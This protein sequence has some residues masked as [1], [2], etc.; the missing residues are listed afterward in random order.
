MIKKKTYLAFIIALFVS[1]SAFSQNK[2]SLNQYIESYKNVAMDEMRIY[3]IPASIKLAQGVLESGFG[4]SDLA[5]KANNHFGIKCSGW[6]GKTFIKDDDAKDECFRSYN[7]AKQSWRDHSEFIKNRER[8]SSLFNLKQDDYKGWAR[9][10]LRAGYA[11]NTNYA[12]MLIRIIEENKLH[13]YDKI[14]LAGNK[15][16]PAI[17][18]KRPVDVKDPDDFAPV[19]L[20]REVLMNN[21]I[22]YIIAVRG[23]TPRKIADEFDM[24][25]WQINK[26]NDLDNNAVLTQGQIIYLQPKKRRGDIN[27][28]IV[29]EGEDIYL[30]SQKYGVRIK[31]ICKMN[32]L[33][34]GEEPNVGDV[35]K[36][37]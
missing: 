23:D 3:G 20:N 19:A 32:D 36:L 27:S 21:R 16:I 14:V 34:P 10:L 37:R 28:H 9:G 35:I 22:R 31:N 5:V 7:D 13:E 26:Y 17:K 29:K 15:S 4:N 30:I 11:T 6:Q 12:N 8:Y 25:E 1:I 18:D 2:I 33:Q 24:R